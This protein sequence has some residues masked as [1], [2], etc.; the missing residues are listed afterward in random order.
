M[1]PSLSILSVAIIAA[2]LCGCGLV[3]GSGNIVSESRAVSGFTQVALEGSGDLTISQGD[4][5]GLIIEAD[6]NLLPYIETEVR[7]GTLHI[8]FK[9]PS[10][11]IPWPTQ[12]IQYHL[13]MRTIEAVKLYGSGDIRSES[14]EAGDI[15]FIIAGSGDISIGE[16]EAD[17]VGTSISGSGTLR[18]DQVTAE[19]ISATISGSGKFFLAGQVTEQ[20]IAVSGSGDYKAFDL[21]SQT[22][23]LSISGSG[24]IELWVTDSLDIQ[25]SGSGD[26]RYYGSPASSQKVSGSGN[27]SSLGSR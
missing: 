23:S 19:S 12:T 20:Q 18:I 8:G 26:V 22:V 5:E 10:P 11:I 9:T 21:E 16:L 24:D 2:L 3:Q 14:I 1:K 4:A 15:K 6:D 7:D 13:S 27:I 17:T 25:I